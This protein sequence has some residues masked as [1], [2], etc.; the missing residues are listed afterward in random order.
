MLR[1][2]K[3]WTIKRNSAI[4][5]PASPLRAT[6]RDRRYFDCGSG[7]YRAYEGTWGRVDKGAY[8]LVTFKSVYMDPFDLG[9]EVLGHHPFLLPGWRPSG[10]EARRFLPRKLVMT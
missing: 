2:D 9:N 3:Q 1:Y 4:A 6:P 10:L 8:D 7:M 5:D